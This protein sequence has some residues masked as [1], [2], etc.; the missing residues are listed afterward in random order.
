MRKFVTLICCIFLLTDVKADDVTANV[1]P[2]VI[3]M[4][5]GAIT[6]TLT[7]G[8]APYTFSWTGPDGFVSTEQDI[9]SLAPGEYCVT[10]LDAFCG[11]AN[12]C[13]TV[14]ETTANAIA[15]ID[16]PDI[17]ILVGPNPFTNGFDI[18]VNTSVAGAYT[19]E[20]Q[21]ISGKLIVA[22]DVIFEQGENNVAMRDLPQLSAGSYHVALISPNGTVKATALVHL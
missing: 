15:A 16:Q 3:G 14:T 18:T 7:A 8:M 1:I 20:L 4:N 13:V 11:E 2:T 10:V 22:I 17:S 21:D 19:I 6:L 9:S 5:N 12:I